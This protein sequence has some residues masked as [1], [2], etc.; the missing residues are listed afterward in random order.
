MLIA[1]STAD[2]SCRTATA[3]AAGR[4]VTAM[5][6]NVP[7]T[8]VGRMGAVVY[9]LTVLVATSFWMTLGPY[10]AA[11]VITLILALPSS[12]VGYAVVAVAAVP[13]SVLPAG[14]G[15]LTVL[16]VLVFGGCAILNVV[17]ARELWSRYGRGTG[18]V[19]S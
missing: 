18:R 11:L 7:T 10:S 17:V 13:V 19:P 15:I 12:L 4:Y 16:T 3:G 1:S 9:V 2:E 6:V 8:R 5:E 14:E